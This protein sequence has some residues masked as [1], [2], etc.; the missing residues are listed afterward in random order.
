MV[1][2]TD[3]G[4]PSNYW[5]AGTTRIALA[6]TVYN[7]GDP[8][9]GGGQLLYTPGSG[10]DTDAANAGAQCWWRPGYDVANMEE[11]QFLNIRLV[12]DK[13][14][15]KTA[16]RMYYKLNTDPDWMLYV[17][18]SSWVGVE[19][20]GYIG[21]LSQ[22]AAAD[23]AIDNLRID[24]V[25]P[26][27][28]DLKENSGKYAFS[29]TAV[30]EANG[31]ISVAYKDSLRTVKALT[32]AVTC[33]DATVTPVVLDGQVVTDENAALATGMS[34][35]LSKNNVVFVS[36]P[37][38]VAAKPADPTTSPSAESD[39]T[40]A[41]T[42]ATTPAGSDSE[43]PATGAALPFAALA[44]TAL[45]AGALILTKKARG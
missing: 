39:A 15:D 5:T 23:F 37:L 7:V 28:L 31:K 24:S 3:V 12:F 16:M 36:V 6:P 18:H 10:L 45:A 44:L 2:L 43:A 30:T 42:T 27:K 17:E 11:G 29:D 20:A 26:Q 22:G 41:P 34:L 35:G 8:V 4:N 25:V 32:A 33:E 38:E 14:G 40:T 19:S 21:F 13:A 9:T 1:G